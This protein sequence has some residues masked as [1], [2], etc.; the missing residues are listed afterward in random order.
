M[1]I[2]S[3]NTH[4]DTGMIGAR[5]LQARCPSC[6]PTVLK[7]N[8]LSNEPKSR[9]THHQHHNCFTALFLGPPGWA[10]DGRELL[11]FIVQGEI[12]RGRHTD[13]PAG[14]N[15]SQTNQCP[16]PP[17]PIF[18]YGPDALP[19]AQPNQ[20]RQST[21]GNKK[22]V[23]SRKKAVDIRLLNSVFVRAWIHAWCSLIVQ[24]CY[25]LAFCD[26]YFT[27]GNETTYTRTCV[28]RY[29]KA[30]NTG[31]LTTTTSQKRTVICLP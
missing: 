30:Q 12:N 2:T 16:P 5:L 7:H 26:H 1:V 23:K 20:Q 15:S 8:T 9:K 28:H 17:S 3:T 24:T 22:G 29:M 10:G 4:T 13:H 11:D 31:L 27:Y 19:A 18:F 21:E 14:R 6:H 25:H